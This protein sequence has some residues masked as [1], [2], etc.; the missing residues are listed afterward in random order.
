MRIL[1]QLHISVQEESHAKVAWIPLARMATKA[2]FA[3]CVQKGTLNNF[4]D[5]G[6]ARQRRGLSPR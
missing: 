4:N 1:Y 6:N 2:P 3:A 5:A